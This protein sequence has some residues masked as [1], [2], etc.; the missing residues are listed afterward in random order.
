MPSPSRKVAKHSLP[1]SRLKIIRPVN[2]SV[3]PVAT[4]ISKPTYFSRISPR[5]FVRGTETGYGSISRTI[6]AARFSLRIRSCSGRSSSTLGFEAEPA[7]LSVL[8][9]WQV[10]RLKHFAHELDEV[11]SMLNQAHGAQWFLKHPQSRVPTHL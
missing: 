4:S 10:Y 9:G 3:S 2:D 8:I 6:K 11:Q 5:D 7:V 1:V